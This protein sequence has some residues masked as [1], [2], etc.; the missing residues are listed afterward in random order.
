MA[1]SDTQA[2]N[3]RGSPE[4]VE[5]RRAARKLNRMLIEGAAGGVAGDGRTERR[6]ARLLRELEEGTRDPREG[7]KP[8]EILQRAH[9]LLVLGETLT[10]LR[11]VIRVHPRPPIDPAQAREL[12]AEI[13]RAYGFRTEVYE[14]LGL[15]E[16]AL[17]GVSDEPRRRGRPPRVG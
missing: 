9:D 17:R 13:Q 5:K 10:A 11:K 14:F 8:I 4:A 12:L 1:K 2:Q 7:L 15:P 3:L 16:D 6:R